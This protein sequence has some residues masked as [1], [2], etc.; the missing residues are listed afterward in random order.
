VATLVR[1]NANKPTVES[2]AGRMEEEVRKRI[3]A[4]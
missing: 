2:G 1:N 3:A 4:F